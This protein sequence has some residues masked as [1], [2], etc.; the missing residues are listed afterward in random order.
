MGLLIFY[1]QSCSICFLYSKAANAAQHSD[2]MPTL[3]EGN[4]QHAA[5]FAVYCIKYISD[6][7]KYLNDILKYIHHRNVGDALS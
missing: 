3:L 2:G 5:Q 4:H 6:I 1:R 7:L